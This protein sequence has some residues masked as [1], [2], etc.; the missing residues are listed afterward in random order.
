[1]HGNMDI[2]TQNRSDERKRV[3][4]NILLEIMSSIFVGLIVIL[5]VRILFRS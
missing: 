3:I 4:E 5:L 2:N 1:M